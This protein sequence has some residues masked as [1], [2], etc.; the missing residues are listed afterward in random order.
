MDIRNAL[1]RC[2]IFSWQTFLGCT[3]AAIDVNEG[4]PASELQNIRQEH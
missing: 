3:M 1:A 2:I 4:I